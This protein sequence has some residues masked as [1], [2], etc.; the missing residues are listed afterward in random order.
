[1]ANSIAWAQPD[2]TGKTFTMRCAR[3]YVYWNGS[4]M[5]GHASNATEF[6]IVS[7]DNNTYLFDATNNA[8]VC[9]TTAA[10]A[11][12]NGNPA[13]EST[14]D[15]SKVV[16]NISF[17]STNITDYPYYVQ[18]DQFT[19]WL[20]MDGNPNVYFN[21]WITFD[22]GNT[23]KI[24]VVDIDFDP[25]A[26]IAMLD[27]YFNPTATVVYEISDANGVVFTSDAIPASIGAEITEL[28]A[29]FQRSFCTYEV[30][31][32]TLVAGE[33]T[34]KVKVTYDLP[35]KASASFD[36]ATWYYSTIRG[37]KY[38]RADEEKKDGNG[39]Y[40]TNSTNE[41]TDVYK[42]AF[43]G[44][45]YRN[46]FI[47]NKGAGAGKYLAMNTQPE[48]EEVA[49][50]AST[51]KVQWA[52]TKN[53]TG[54]T[55][56]SITGPNL[57]LNDA[58]N[59]GNLGT[60]NSAAGLNDAGSRWDIEEVLEGKALLAKTIEDANALYGQLAPTAGEVGYPSAAA[61]STFKNAIDAAQDVCDAPVA[62]YET[63]N[64]TLEAAT[65]AVVA[66]ENINYTPRTDVYYTIV[67]ARGAIVYNPEKKDFVDSDNGDA[68]YLW[69]DNSDE[70]DNTNVNNLWG[71]I[72]KDGHYYMYN[73]GKQQFA[74]VG[75]G[76]YGP[77]WIFSNTPAYITLDNGIA[78]EIAA[79]KVRVRATIATTEQSYT[80]CVSTSYRGPVITYDGKNDGGV[81]MLFTAS[82][83]AIDPDVTAVIKT[84]IGDLT[85]YCEA[86][87]AA[88]KSAEAKNI[89][90]GLGEFAASDEFTAALT[91]AKA[92][93]AKAD[94]E[95]TKEELQ[96]AKNELEASFATLTL[97]M[98]DPGF[99]NIVGGISGMYL[100]G[101]S[102]ENG[103]YAMAV[104]S[105]ANSIF[106][107]DG[108]ILVNFG[109]GLSNGM[110]ASSWAWVTEDKA[111]EVAFQDGL[112]DGGYAIKSG[113]ANFYDNGDNTKSADRGGNLTINTSTN[114][115]YTSWVL[116][117]IT[118]LPVEITEAGFATLYSPV[119]LKIANGV[120]AYTAV[121]EEDYLLL[122]E[123]TGVIPSSIPVILA[124]DEGVYI[125]R[126]TDDVDFDGKSDL[127]GSVGGVEKTT[128]EFLTL[129]IIN[130]TPGFHKYI[131]DVVR[132]FQAY[133]TSSESVVKVLFPDE[134][135]VTANS[136]T[137]EYG[138]ALPTFSYTSSGATLV[139]TPS[140]SCEATS[141]SPVG[142][143]PIVI[144]KGSV[145]NYNDRYVN[146][147][148]TIKKAPLTIAADNKTKYQGDALPTLTVTYSGFKNQETSNVLTKQ[149]TITTTATATSAPGDYPITVSGAEAE[150]YDITHVNGTLTV[151]LPD[152]V[153]V[154]ADSYTIEYGD[155][156]PNFGF[157]S[158]GA[159]LVGTPSISC[160]ATSASPV[161]TYP[162]VIAKGNVT[163]YN[164][165]YVNGTLTIKKAPL[166]VS[167]GNYT[168]NEREENPEFT[169]TYTGFKNGE[170]EEVLTQKPVATTTADVMSG[171]GTYPI[172]VSGGAAENYEL[173]YV[174]GTLTVTQVLHT[175][176][177][178][179]IGN[180]VVTCHDYASDED[181]TIKDA[182]TTHVSFSQ[183]DGLDLSILPDLGYQ[184]MRLMVSNIDRTEDVDDE[185][186]IHLDAHGD[187]N[188]IAQFVPQSEVVVSVNDAKY[189][190]PDLST[191]EAEVAGINKAAAHV[192][193]P[194]TM[195]YRG[196]TWRI[197]KVADGAFASCQNLVSISI[198]ASVKEAG[199]GLFEGDTHL[200]AIE[201]NSDIPLTRTLLGTLRNPNLLYYV[202]QKEL[203]EGFSN[204]ITGSNESGWQAEQIQLTDNEAVIHDFYAPK[205]FTAQRISYTHAYLQET[206]KGECRGWE[207]LVLP[208]DVQ[209]I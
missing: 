1:M 153:V 45:P 113:T 186:H 184:L 80:M 29:D 60:W 72:E 137:I 175:A 86:L 159:T 20:N 9:H 115:R 208:F 164:D 151:L 51:E 142:T 128:N 107:F 131:G 101:G 145:S 160:E 48:M 136:Y 174:S 36:N 103:K 150:N 57:Y 117:E 106:F 25:S 132:G 73:V 183:I 24:E 120:K 123:L 5:K 41:K 199:T 64:A 31:E 189:R 61:I 16:K 161:G 125:F 202:K 52:V 166:T 88:I 196:R 17:G 127:E 182:E 21:R 111:S 94:N 2:V 170:N 12:T 69:Y 44:N 206:N 35:F 121:I 133:L 198:P 165:H 65:A 109:T 15:F 152:E 85:P 168:R 207:S 180:G 188:I 58:G 185:G 147:T 62:D 162:I 172:T 95:L 158:T 18:E 23:Y 56:R 193:I 140:I 8:F 139:G 97:N 173:N 190:I 177:I 89:G 46:F 53:G 71:F 83:V 82:S 32:T 148:L 143:Y 33:N 195:D 47:V 92:L 129:Q 114:P 77:T 78:Q 126:V 169:L 50:P 130:E 105:D 91:T 104:K 197:T 102:A 67:N 163:N 98:P 192:T 167:V 194:A 178:T 70:F 204:V 76:T 22:G 155:A 55:F 203:A 42:W 11:G 10:T 138:D 149:P 49:E 30:T 134:V 34:V 14:S 191:D 93:L 110:T 43:V 179:C 87:A 59:A 100:A 40:M 119:A 74:S 205:A 27:A 116:E 144:S 122:E 4:A 38:L 96:T 209:T 37:S 28:P 19:N 54:L 156:L 84:L 81:P 66:P 6:A 176:T 7:Y 135:V 68:E 154:T 181:V 157:T 118:D 63:A 90:T 26:A 201:W 3:G 79:P 187:L 39:R 200:A 112:T 13:V 75:K 146:G 99:Y 108:S 124:G 171:P 141:A